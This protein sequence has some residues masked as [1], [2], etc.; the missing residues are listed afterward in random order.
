M[1][2]S[3]SVEID[4]PI[5]KVIELF[6]NPDNLKEWQ[7]GFV[8]MEPISGTPGEPGAK[9]KLTYKSGK[10]ELNMIETI[11][12]KNLPDELTATYEAKSMI[13]TMKNK[14]ISINDTRTRYEVDVEYT[15][16]IGFLPSLMAMLR[17]RF[18]QRQ[19]QKWLDQ[20]KDFAEKTVS[21]S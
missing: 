16:F 15:K 1:K 6:D 2:Y 12:V 3:C 9:S 21:E 20:F 10:Q 14:F 11:I 19:T 5:E 18:F 17:P 7:D 4:L 8:G 13:N